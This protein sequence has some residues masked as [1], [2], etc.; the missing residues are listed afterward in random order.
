MTDSRPTAAGLSPYPTFGERL[1]DTYGRPSG[2]DYL[3][4]ILAILVI[5]MHAGLTTGGDI[6]EHALWT[7]PL[8]PLVKAILPMFFGLSGF[9]VAG[10][11]ERCRTLG[12]VDGIPDMHF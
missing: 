3:R 8:R 6:P 10:S 9:L 5:A 7:S 1:K 12:R 4:I 2:F 11:L